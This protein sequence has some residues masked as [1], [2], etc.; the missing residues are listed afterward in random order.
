MDARVAGE[1]KAVLERL[2]R[3]LAQRPCRGHGGGQGGAG[4]E[5][6]GGRGEDGG[7]LVDI[8]E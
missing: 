1:I 5:A 4:A 8:V 2:A 7:Q 3:L 6:E